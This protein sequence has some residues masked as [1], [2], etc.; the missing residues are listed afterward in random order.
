MPLHHCL[1]WQND[2]HRF[3]HLLRRMLGPRASASAEMIGCQSERYPALSPRPRARFI[4]ARVRGDGSRL[5]F[6]LGRKRK[7]DRFA[8][9]VGGLNGRC[10]RRLRNA[11]HRPR[12][13]R[14]FNLLQCPQRQ[15]ETDQE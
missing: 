1:C 5:L 15:P 10:D 14:P 13:K 7:H 9:L 6:R 12:R 2:R 11:R 8:G 4:V 3:R